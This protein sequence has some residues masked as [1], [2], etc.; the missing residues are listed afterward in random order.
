LTQL[1]IKCDRKNRH[2]AKNG[3][4][5][6]RLTGKLSAGYGNELMDVRASRGLVGI[7]TELLQPKHVKFIILTNLGRSV[8]FRIMEKRTRHYNLED[9]KAV[10]A[11]PGI[12]PFTASA[13]RGGAAL[14]LTPQQMR[15]VVLSLSAA[16]FRKSMTAHQDNRIWQDVYHGRT[17]DGVVVYIK[18]TG[19]TDGRPPVIS[20]KEK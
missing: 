10:V 2:G 13:R 9:V 12:Y 7:L 11:D 8:I 16:D 15:D 17:Q 14:G 20:F 18:I 4:Y 1:E 19:Y 5:G 6:K 3:I